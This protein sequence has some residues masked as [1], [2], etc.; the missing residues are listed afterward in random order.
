MIQILCEL[1]VDTVD[2]WFS[3]QNEVF[4]GAKINL[5]QIFF[6]YYPI[7]YVYLIIIQNG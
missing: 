3:Y 4:D 5:L 1:S 6:I 7:F 2:S